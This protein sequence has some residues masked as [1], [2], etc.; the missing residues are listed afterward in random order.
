MSSCEVDNKLPGHPARTRTARG[1]PFNCLGAQCVLSNVNAEVLRIGTSR[2]TGTKNSIRAVVKIGA[3][4]VVLQTDRRPFTELRH[5]AE[6]ELNPRDFKIIVVK[7]GYLFPELRDYAPLH[8]MALSPGFGDQRLERLPYRNL[9][10]PIFPL[11]GD[12]RWSM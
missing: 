6:L 9:N 12:V 3:V 5:F 2:Q 10:R 1:G 8:I 4:I 7:E 11:D